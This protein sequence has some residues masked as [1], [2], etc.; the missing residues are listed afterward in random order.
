MPAPALL[1][2][3]AIVKATGIDRREFDV[4][5][6]VTSST[7]RAVAPCQLSAVAADGFDGTAFLRFVAERFFLGT[8][9]LLVNEGMAAVVIALEIC[10]RS[11][12]AQIAVD[13]LVIDVEL[14]LYVLR[15]F[16]CNVSHF[17]P[18][19]SVVQV[20]KKDILRNGYLRTED[21]RDR[22][23]G[24]PRRMDVSA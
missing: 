6:D 5:R 10:G 13:A 16:V 11:F 23:R 1:S 12:A 18:L 17:A 15:I 8:F 2:E 3:P 21:G 4:N 7:R 19:K 24:G 22:A 14:P 9:G 20:R